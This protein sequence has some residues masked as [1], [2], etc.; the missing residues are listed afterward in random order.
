MSNSKIIY[1]KYLFF[2]KKKSIS[3]FFVLVITTLFLSASSVNSLYGVDKKTENNIFETNGCN[4]ESSYENTQG[5][6]TQEGFGT[7]FIAPEMD[8]SH[9][10]G[11]ELPKKY[12][13]L[14]PPSSFDWRTIGAVTSVKNQGACNACYA[15]ASIAC[16]ES[17]IIILGGGSTDLSEDNVKEC[18]WY[19]SCCNPSNFYKVASFL[20]QEGTVLESC[21]PYQAG[22]NTVPPCGSCAC[23]QTLF[24]WRVISANSVP[25]TNVLKNYIYNKGPVYA[26]IWSG[27]DPYDATWRNEFVNYDGSYTLYKSWTGNTDHAVLIVG[28]DDSLSHAGGTGAWICKNSWGTSWG[29]TCGYGA[30]K[31]YFTIAYASAAIGKYSSFVDQWSNYDT[32]GGVSYYDEGGWNYNWGYSSNTAWGLCK[33]GFMVNT[34][35]SR[36]EFWTNDKTIDVDVF[37]YD[38]FDG[39]TLSNLLWSSLNHAFDE[40]GYHGVSI[41]PTLSVMGMNSIYVVVKFTNSNYQYPIVSDINGPTTTGCTYTS[42]DGSSG[43][44]FDRGTGSPKSDVAIRLRFS[45]GNPPNAPIISGTAEGKPGKIYSYDFV[46]TDT[47]GDKVSY[48]IKW[49]DGYDTDWTAFGNSGVKYTED[50]TWSLLGSYIIQAKTKDIYGLESNWTSFEIT[51][52]RIKTVC[53]LVFFKFFEI[54]ILRFKTINMKLT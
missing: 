17:K 15:F 16:F 6:Q 30:E 13:S 39:S 25:S 40:A 51:I 41:I 1:K 36:V 38:D 48:Y 19:H 46:S 27:S 32:S 49:G 52:P 18:E 14:T 10:T 47:N 12:I 44:W 33:F 28:W 43:S 3:F 34:G 20:S 31:G 4:C 7:G 23:Q 11:Q 54:L 37:I 35:V 2:K 8:L 9:L 24:D 45:G 50:H 53:S 21:D 29:G 42:G 26:A 5:Q 22:H